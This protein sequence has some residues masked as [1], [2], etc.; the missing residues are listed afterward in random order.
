MEPP[1]DDFEDFR[2]RCGA[3]VQDIT[4]LLSGPHCFTLMFDILKKESAESSWDRTEAIL[5][6]LSAIAP[7]VGTKNECPAVQG[8]EYP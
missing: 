2:N 7:Q 4:M 5:W 8:T 3:V 6:V 1:R